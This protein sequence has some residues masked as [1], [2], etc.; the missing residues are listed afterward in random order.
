MPTKG[1]QLTVWHWNGSQASAE[2]L[3]AVYLGRCEST[4][5]HAV[6]VTVGL[7]TSPMIVGRQVFDTE[8]QARWWGLG[9]LESNKMF[10]EFLLDRINKGAHE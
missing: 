6:L 3:E 10:A 2:P 4:G 7:S 9:F 5:E 1:E 8:I